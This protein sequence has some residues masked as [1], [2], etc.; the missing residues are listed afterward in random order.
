[1]IE[2]IAERGAISIADATRVFELYLS[3]KI[4]A[5]TRTTNGFDVKHGSFLDRDVIRRALA[6]CDA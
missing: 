3:K 6:Q 2:A 5:I 1:M 4:R